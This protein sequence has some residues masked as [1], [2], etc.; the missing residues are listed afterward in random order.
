MS[1]VSITGKAVAVEGCD[2]ACFQGLDGLFRSKGSVLLTHFV[3][4]TGFVVFQ[5]EAEAD[6]ARGDLNGHN[7]DTV[8]LTTR[9]P[10]ATED[11]LLGQM[12][13]VKRLEELVALLGLNS[14][15]GIQGP[16]GSASSVFTQQAAAS[17]TTAAGATQQTPATMATTTTAS[18][19]S[20]V[21][22]FSSA[23]PKLPFFSGSQERKDDASFDLWALEVRSLIQ[24]GTYSAAVLAQAVRRSLRGAASHVLLH[25]GQGASV[26]DIVQRLEGIY[27]T[28]ASDAALLQ[29]FYAERQKKDESVA[30]WAGRLEDI[31][32]QLRQRGKVNQVSSDEM[33][34]NKL[35]V[36]LY[37]ERLKAATR[38]KFD[39]SATYLEL[40]G[41]SRSVEQEMAQEEQLNPRHKTARISQEVV[42]PPPVDFAA[43]ASAAAV[44]A[45]QPMMDRMMAF[46]EKQGQRPAQQHHSPQLTGPAERS[47]P[48]PEGSRQRQRS[49]GCYRCGGLDHYKKGCRAILP[50]NEQFPL[51]ESW[52][53]R[54]QEREPQE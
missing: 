19:S 43:V 44:K 30:A 4:N 25:L 22:A 34:R 41:Y 21:Q 29:S 23:V 24:E 9:R 7:V 49:R 26:S 45:V 3:S 48:Q 2:Q 39:S 50:G 5:E 40:L 15:V 52:Q 54:E 10:T 46:M 11:D 32:S 20:G 1:A 37:S 33:L 13:R 17:S 36:G 38:H 14:T 35:W 12:L 18:T 47:G 6:V 27:G 53:Q 28:V 51:S 16:A 31:V 8:V 42:Q